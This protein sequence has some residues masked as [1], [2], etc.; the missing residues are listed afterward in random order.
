MI[1]VTIVCH[2]VIATLYN[3][4]RSR[5]SREGA[6]RRIRTPSGSTHETKYE[7]EDDFT[8]AK[9]VNIGGAVAFVVIIIIF[10]I[11]FWP[12]ALKEFNLGPKE[13]IEQKPIK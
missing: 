13:I 9:Y 5:R 4:G 6:F 8:L 10:N 2:T 1:V 3:A 11:G 7:E 12:S